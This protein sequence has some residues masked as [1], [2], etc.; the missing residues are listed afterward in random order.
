[1]AG[2]NRI[3]IKQSTNRQKYAV[4]KSSNNKTVA[5]TETYKTKQGVDNAAQ[6]LKKILKNAIVIDTLKKKSK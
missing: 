5:V 1:M 4:I 2:K 3:V 6:A